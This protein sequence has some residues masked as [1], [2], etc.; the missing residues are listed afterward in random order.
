MERFAVSVGED[1]LA[2]LHRRLDATRWPDEAPD[3]IPE[4]GF[5]LQR[6][7]ELAAYW[8]DGYDWRAAEAVL[9]G[10]E[11][12][13]GD[14]GVHFM[15]PSPPTPARRSCSCT[16]GRAASGS[17]CGSRRCSPTMRG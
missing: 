2:D 5:G 7:R 3:A 17:S 10:F 11:Q 9:N 16:A 4:H 12:H 1:V 8:R 15:T 13:V 14:G 6:A